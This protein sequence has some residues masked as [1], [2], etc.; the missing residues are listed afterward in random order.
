MSFESASL[1][2][3]KAVSTNAPQGNRLGLFPM[4]T[5]FA[6]MTLGMNG[7][8]AQAVAEVA[9]E[10]AK[11]DAG[12][13]IAT[14]EATQLPAVTVEG[15][16]DRYKP[17]N[18]AS[19]KFTEPLRDTP[20][21]ITVLS[22]DLI[23]D[24]GVLTLRQILS[25]VP[26]ITFGAGE[27]G[28]GF[29]DKINIRGFDASNDISIDGIRDSAQ[30]S[31]NDPFNIEQIEVFKGASSVN[32]GA[33]AVGGSIN[34]VSKTPEAKAFRR[35]S[36]GVGT[37]DYGRFTADVNQPISDTA[38]VRINAMVHQQK[39]AERDVTSASRWGVAP[40]VSLG[41]GTPTQLTLSYYHQY[42]DNIPDY[43][44]PFRNYQPVPG[45]SRS[46]Y[47]GFS[48]VDKQQI[49]NDTLTSIL[50][51][52]FNSQVK[53]RN[54][55]R[56]GS[57]QTDATTNG[58]EGDVCLVIGDYPLGTVMPVSTTSPPPKCTT[59]GTYTPRSGPNGQ[60]RNTQNDILVNQT[61]V[62]WNFNTGAVAHTAVTGIQI[63]KETYHLD[64]GSIFRNGNGTTYLPYPTTSLYDPNNFWTLPL[65]PTITTKTDTSVND[66][67]IYAFDTIKFGQHWIVNG[68]L[69][70]EYNRS[71][72][73]TFT[74]SAA[75]A[76]TP[77]GEFALAANNPLS[78]GDKLLSYRLGLIYK[79]TEIG[80][81][82]AAF[83]NS[84]LP[85]SYGGNTLGACANTPATSTANASNTCAV[86]PET[87]ISYEIGTKWDVLDQKLALTADVFRTERTNFKVA[88][89]D[90]TVAFQQLDG[91]SRVEGI[92][93]GAAGQITKNWS[94]TAGYTFQRSEIIRSISKYSLSQGKVDPQAGR[95]LANLP[96]NAVSL[97]TTYEWP[98]G[99]QLGYG[100]NYV[101]DLYQTATVDAKLDGYVLQNALFGY[102]ANKDLSF[103]LNV[104]N[105]TNRVYYQQLRGTQASGWVNPG[106][107]RNAVLT[108]N[109]NF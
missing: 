88:S 6:A 27:G 43:G 39:F 76:T 69:R 108:A 96:R 71:T 29:G 93:L 56:F 54:A 14:S 9:A 70:Y 10:G 16:V 62:T 79:P 7:A 104:N 81:V 82:Y 25:N 105:L 17:T 50:E 4:G 90:A 12:A 92:E 107:G 58:V 11:A 100:L 98:M 67:A 26:G 74:R 101:S 103:A 36:G 49:K 44:I 78:T 13:K 33:G 95:P 1:R 52:N 42:D 73:T 47:Y 37:Q 97:W 66:S 19:P 46:N 83:G 51:H 109:Y 28:S 87:A 77:P 20:M 3:L 32:S 55:T 38:A 18:V 40:S 21:S 63:S 84:K 24:Q 72:A 89:G 64:S 45:V 99:L 53:V 30:T 75:T 106:T 91:E 34:L 94:L 102:K 23:A 86:K 41:L 68:G 57:N 5:M 35:L 59:A 22:K 80:T 15:T 85:T 65:N 8:H 61:D 31:R 48:N 2:P 60:I